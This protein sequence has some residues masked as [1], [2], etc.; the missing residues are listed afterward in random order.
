MFNFLK[1]CKTFGFTIYKVYAKIVSID[2]AERNVK[3][4]LKKNSHNESFNVKE[5]GQAS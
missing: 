1:L 3:Y 4:G 5:A 2:T